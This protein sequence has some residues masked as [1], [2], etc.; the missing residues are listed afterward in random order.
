MKKTLLLISLLIVTVFLTFSYDAGIKYIDKNTVEFKLYAPGK[1]WVSLVG[2]FNDF[3]PFVDKM[4]YKDGYWTITKKF[5]DGV[6]RYAF[7]VEGKLIGDPYAREV[8]WCDKGPLA[9]LNIP[10]KKFKWTDSN[11]KFDWRKAVIYELHVKDFAGGFKGVLKKLDYLKKL[12]INA[13]EMMPIWE[14]P[15]D[16][17]W[18]Y[19][20][21]YFFAP[22][23]AYGKPADLKR[24]INEA[25]KRGIAI[26]LDMVFNHCA[27]DCPLNQLYPY[28]ENPYFSTDGNPWGLPDFNHW[29]LITQKFTGD[30]IEYW[31]KEYH[32]DGIRFDYTRGIGYDGTHGVS[33]LAWKAKQVKPDIYLIAEQIPED[34]HIVNTTY[35]DAVWHDHFHDQLK[36]DLREGQFEGSNVNMAHTAQVMYFG[37]PEGFPNMLSVINYTENHDEERVIYECETNNIPYEIAKKRTILGAVVVMGSSGVPMIWQGQE[38]GFSAKRTIDPTPVDWTLLKKNED[39]FKIWKRL[40]HLRTENP[41]L[42]NPY[43]KF[44][45]IDHYAQVLVWERRYG[46]YQVVFAVNFKTDSGYTIH[47]NLDNAEYW[48]LIYNKVISGLSTKTYYLAPNSAM[49]LVKRVK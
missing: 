46:D 9:V 38:F 4:D 17:S 40:I 37:G 15:M 43:L 36:A 45:F 18:G 24:L 48:D 31:I 33:Y 11:F 6:Y 16:Y 47:L 19:N 3:N 44:L 42:S 23:K 34:S 8:D 49:V 39:L 10:E 20:P 12:G 28:N 1:K 22:E 35:I 29:S 27:H 30:V 41:A 5:K 13:I 21:A 14:F 26:I 7:V 2:D 32:I 25:H